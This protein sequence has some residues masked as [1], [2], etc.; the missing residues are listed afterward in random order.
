MVRVAV[1][2]EMLQWA[3]ERAS[4]DLDELA[5]RLPNLPAW[6][7]GEKKPTMKQLERFAKA[8][9]VPFGYLFLP[10]PPKESLPIPDF[11]TIQG[12]IGRPSPN[13]LDTIYAMQRRQDWLRES[14]IEYE[15]TPL[16]FVGS[17]SLKG[18]PEAVGQDMRRILGIDNNWGI[19]SSTWPESVGK[20]RT[21]I[22]RVGIMAVING[23][24]GNNTRRKL[25]VKEFRGFSL[26]D[27]YAPLIFVNGADAKAAQMF[28]MAHEL[29]HIW[30]GQ[31]G[32]GLS[33]FENLCPIGT[34]VE[35]FCDRAAAEFLLPAQA[36]KSQWDE[37]KQA[38]QPFSEI[39]KRF[40]VSPIVAG[41]RAM[42][43][44]LVERGEFFEFY[45]NYTSI[46]YRKPSDQQ[47]GNFYSNQ[48]VRVGQM[49]ATKVIRAALEGRLSFREAYSLT[50]LK[51]GTF[52][53]YASHLGFELS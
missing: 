2:P 25:N 1:R 15:A 45:R 50:G 52:Q 33:G 3:R 32:E 23:V 34:E 18:K 43:L 10:K 8:T 24:V 20:L 53:E 26:C 9:Y 37:F 30:L 44:N 41:R 39:S 6:E 11:R 36:L 5:S 28:T 46:E 14:Q 49:F 16:D 22:E 31:Q 47:G 35:E 12:E 13:L 38:P 42:D 51:G 17:A 21:A 40:K 29:A 27:D 48:N 7:R 19:N 4:I